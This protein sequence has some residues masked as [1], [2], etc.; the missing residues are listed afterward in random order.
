[1]CFR[2]CAHIL[3]LITRHRIRILSALH[4]FV[5]CGLSSSA[6]FFHLISQTARFAEKK[7]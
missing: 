2:A 6:A 5:I 3:A 4:Y 1:M 7:V